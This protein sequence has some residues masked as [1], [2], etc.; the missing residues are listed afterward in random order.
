MDATPGSALG[1]LRREDQ[2]VTPWRNGGGVTR[3]VAFGLWGSRTEFEWRVSIAEVEQ[4]GPFSSFPGV[5]RTIML[6]EGEQMVLT[7]DGVERPL[8][9]RVPFTFSGDSATTCQIP[10]GPTRDLNVMTQRGRVSATTVVHDLSDGRALPVAGATVAVLLTGE[11]VVVGPDGSRAELAPLDALGPSATVRMVMGDGLV[12]VV[13]IE[14]Y[15]KLRPW[16]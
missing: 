14:N 3:E 1:V 2:P 15:R 12:A 5:E 7:V 13:R 16:T 10:A 11:A 4:A 6:L 8:Q 9:R